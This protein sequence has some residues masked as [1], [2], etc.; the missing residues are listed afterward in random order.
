M[1]TKPKATP[2][3]PF[4]KVL[5]ANRGEIA[6]R[7]IRACRQLGLET[8]AICSEADRTA[9]YLGA[10]DETV[11]IGPA[12]SAASYLD[13]GAILLAA[14]ATGADAIHPGYGFLS[15]NAAFA[16]AVEDAGICF[17]GPSSRIVQLMG[18]KI[19]AKEAMQR[20]GVPCVPGSKGPLPDTPAAALTIAEKI[21]F[22]VIVKAAG[23]G[24]GRGMRVV[25]TADELTQAISLTREEAQRAFGNPQLY[26]EKYLERPRHI[27]IQVIC[28]Q[29]GNAV[30]LGERDCSIQRRHQ[31]LIEEA[32]AIGIARDT[33]AELGEKCAA[34]CQAIGYEGVGTFEFL[35]EDGIFA[36]IEMNTRIQV[37]HP[38]TEAVTGIDLVKEQ[39]SVAMG[40]KL[41]F[42][43]TD[44]RTFGHS[45]EC[46][47]NAEK[48]FDGIPSPG[49]ITR[50]LSPGGPGVR[51]DT[52][53]SAGDFVPPQYDSLIAKLIVHDHDRHSCI[54]KMRGA[55]EQLSIQGINVNTDLHRAVLS[56]NAFVEGGT[57]IHF[58][59]DRLKD[60]QHNAPALR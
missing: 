20:S 36:F 13:A 41:A 8:V 54:E 56:E 39:I 40:K 49:R 7:V 37:E 57:T 50:F 2:G 10:A 3:L 26:L 12:A 48:P 46:R 38:V 17:I 18:D 19:L 31:K 42:A 59:E 28:D 33:I 32:P 29:H 51:F 55:L 1:S 24:G 52:H 11:C 21:G 43:Q 4:R 27:E 58:L 44:I 47:I 5:I 23:G 53:L 16:T 45:M 9:S 25:R 15:E 22:P 30:W 60:W 34:A 14:D 35:Y 6:L